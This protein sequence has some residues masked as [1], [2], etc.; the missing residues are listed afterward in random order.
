LNNSFKEIAHVEKIAAAVVLSTLAA[1]WFAAPG[2]F[3]G[4]DACRNRLHSDDDVN[5]PGAFVG[6]RFDDYLGAEL[7]Y[8]ELGKRSAST[9]F[10]YKAEQTA[11]SAVATL[12]L[13]NGL[14][15]FGRLGVN[16]IDVTPMSA[17]STGPTAA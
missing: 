12:P 11:L 8:R 4:V 5:S 16:N 6:Y 1:S 9:G 14:N 15:V 17:R 7:G 3:A 2:S 13:S 10:D